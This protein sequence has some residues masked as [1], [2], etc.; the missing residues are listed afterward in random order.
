MAPSSTQ[1]AQGDVDPGMLHD[2]APA[3]ET[4]AEVRMVIQMAGDR[5]EEVTAAEDARPAEALAVAVLAEVEAAEVAAGSRRPE[6]WVA[7][8]VWR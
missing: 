2:P 7:Y 4:A 3:A 8:S 1:S 6:M 5:V